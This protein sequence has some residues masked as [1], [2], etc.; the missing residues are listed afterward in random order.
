MSPDKIA[1]YI[2]I[3]GVVQGVGYRYFVYRKAGE[4][5][6]KGYVRNLY[7]D[8]VEIEVEGDRGMLLDF[9]KDLKVGPRSAH[10]TRINIEWKE[11]QNNFTEF[12]IK[13]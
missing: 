3:S 4:Y 6:L 8:D 1:A 2:I 5:N 11:P 10:V 13:F 12:Q 9:I 7:S